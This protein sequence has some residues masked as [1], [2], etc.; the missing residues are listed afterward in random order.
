MKHETFS[1][2]PDLVQ[3][4]EDLL[5]IAADLRVQSS[6]LL[7]MPE[8]HHKR[9]AKGR[10]RDLYETIA[11]RAVRIGTRPD[12]LLQILQAIL[13]TKARRGRPV[14]AGDTSRT[15]LNKLTEAIAREEAARDAL[16]AAE[17]EATS[18]INARISIELAC[19]TFGV[20]RIAR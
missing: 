1:D 9:A 10:V 15:L 3:A 11:L 4:I 14:P 13:D 17:K 18:A 6:R 12:A 19:D 5:P 16:I 20:R 2:D 7:A 8:D